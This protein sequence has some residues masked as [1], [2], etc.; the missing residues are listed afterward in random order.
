MGGTVQ[1]WVQLALVPGVLGVQGLGRVSLGA[2]VVGK[3]A[4]W[5]GSGPIYGIREGL[6]DELAS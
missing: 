1:L 2:S 6:P 5:V 3:L 4:G